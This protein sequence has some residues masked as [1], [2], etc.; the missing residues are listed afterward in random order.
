MPERSP[1]RAAGTGTTQSGS[2]GTFRS[3]RV[4]KTA[5][6]TQCGAWRHW[7]RSGRFLPSCR[8]RAWSVSAWAA[9]PWPELW[10]RGTLT[11]IHSHT[12]THTHTLE[13]ASTKTHLDGNTIRQQSRLCSFP[14]VCYQTV[15][16]WTSIWDARNGASVH[17]FQKHTHTHTH[18]HTNTHTYTYTQIRN[19]RNCQLNDSSRCGCCASRIGLEW[20]K[21]V[22][23]SII[24]LFVTVIYLLLLSFLVWT[25][26]FVVRYQ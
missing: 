2:P 4:W 5:D 10:R 26:F 8:C 1:E 9:A 24:D 21:G 18:T 15:E 3:G 22:C 13:W 6:E 20:I 23:L 17:I 14:S 25:C 7:L 19:Y 11:L 16:M 12:H